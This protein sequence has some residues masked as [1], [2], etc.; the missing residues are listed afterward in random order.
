MRRALLAIL[1]LGLTAS[2][3]VTSVSAATSRETIRTILRD[4]EDG[5]LSGTYRSSELRDAARNIGT[6]LDQYSD[7]RD[8]ISAAVLRAASRARAAR[9]AEAAQAS[10]SG[11]GSAGGGAGTAGGGAG[12]AGGGAGTASGSGADSA[13]PEPDAPVADAGF[14]VPGT[15]AAEDAAEL[16][17][18][19]DGRRNPPGPMS[20]AGRTLDVGAPRGVAAVM[21]HDLP[22]PVLVA[23]A[24][25]TLGALA[26]ALPSLHRRVRARRAA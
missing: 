6:D 15:L 7:C 3:P 13:A 25:L 9:A 1:L 18:I 14:G 17:A 26:A 5:A 11:S 8:V 16:A 10:P 2:V 22:T 4:C 24:A 23:L 21:A 19:E 12:T 20:V